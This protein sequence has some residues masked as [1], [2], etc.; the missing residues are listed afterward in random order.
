MDSLPQEII[1]EIIDDLPPSS[2]PS[3]SLVATRWR[4]R[5][6]QHAFSSILL[7]SE[8]RAN[9]WLIDSQSDQGGISSYVKFVKLSRILEWSDP[10]LFSRVLEN[11]TSLT[12]PQMDQVDIPDG[13]LER[14]SHG[15]LSKRITSLSLC[16][17][18]CPLSVVV[19]MILTFSNLRDLVIYYH[20][21]GASGEVPPIQP[22]QPQRRPLD[23]LRITSCPSMVAET[24]TNLLLTPR[25]LVLNV[26]CP[27]ALK[28]LAVSSVTVAELVFIGAY[29]SCGDRKSINDS[30][31]GFPEISSLQPLDSQQF[32]ALTSLKLYTS[33]RSPSPCLRDIMVSISSAPVLASV[34]LQ[35][36]WCFLP[37]F[38]PPW[39]AWDRTDVLLAR[40]AKNAVVEGGLV[41]T[42]ADWRGDE[43][44][45]ALFPK[46]KEV[47]K[48]KADLEE[49][50]IHNLC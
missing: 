17:L 35:C 10:R 29:S 48:I 38:H 24:L 27:S 28:L 9:S 22:I 11:F 40:M 13:A 1:D 19:S 30:F 20:S 47:G 32:P 25:S 39:D 43:V 45:K 5:S 14:I 42:L 31:P 2:L 37:E 12:A 8:P 33:G 3:S 15:E 46:F 36:W 16:S 41:L 4:K 26:W 23:S 18:W 50:N 21:S 44:P 7:S 34:A 49:L 6:Q